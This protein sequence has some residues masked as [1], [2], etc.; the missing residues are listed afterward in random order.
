M[1]TTITEVLNIWNDIG[2]FSYVIPFLLIFAVVFAIL[3]KT[4]ILGDDNDG[5]LAVISVAVGL[6]SLQ[7][8]FVSEFFMIIFPRFGIGLSVFLVL[9]IFIGFFIPHDDQEGLFKKLGW[10]GYVIGIGAVVWALSEWDEW[11]DFGGFGGW[12]SENIWALL[13]LGGVIAVIVIVAGK[14]KDKGKSG[15]KK[16]E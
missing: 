1:V 12:F 16:D 10:V 7:L 4:K 3:K 11:N 13:I 2:V 14:D 5:I 9:L 6:L 15:K 8:D